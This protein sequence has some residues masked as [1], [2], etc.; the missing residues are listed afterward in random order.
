MIDEA[1]RVHLISAN[2]FVCPPLPQIPESIVLPTVVVKAMRQFV[3]KCIAHRA[4]VQ[5]SK[6]VFEIVGIS[7][8]LISILKLLSFYLL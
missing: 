7:L 5:C 6:I 1:L 8:S 2:C 4:I 3:A